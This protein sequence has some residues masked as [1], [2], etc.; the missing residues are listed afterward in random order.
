MGAATFVV[1]VSTV[2]DPASQT[3]VAAQVVSGIGFL[4]AGIIFRE[5]LNVRGLNTAA[6]LWWFAAVGVLAGASSMTA[7]RPRHERHDRPERSKRRRAIVPASTATPAVLG[8]AG[9]VLSHLDPVSRPIA[10]SDDFARA[11]HILKDL[12]LNHPPAQSI[13]RQI[14]HWI[15]CTSVSMPLTDC[16][17]CN[18]E[19]VT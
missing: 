18:R 14:E 2:S 4:G 6:T 8:S 17:S 11:R 1:F 3:R 16:L 12:Y 10:S 9:A 13:E 15:A 7:C 5:G 19:R